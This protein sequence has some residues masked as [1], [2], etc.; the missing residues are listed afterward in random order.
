M[1]RQ[2]LQ[3]ENDQ[4]KEDARYLS[5]RCEDLQSEVANL[6]HW[7]DHFV[8]VCQSTDDKL[9]RLELFSRCNNVRFFN[10]FE[11]EDE[12]NDDCG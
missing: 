10:V 12:N 7:Q 1:S 5:A 9:D 6:Y 11:R 3:C 8:G 4:L 2:S